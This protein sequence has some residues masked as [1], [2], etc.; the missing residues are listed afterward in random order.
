[1]KIL[2]VLK[3]KNQLKK[4]SEKEIGYVKKILQH[5][6]VEPNV[7]YLTEFES[8]EKHWLSATDFDSNISIEKYWNRIRKN[9][10]KKSNAKAKQT[11]K[12]IT[13]EK[14]T[15]IPEKSIIQTKSGRIVKQKTF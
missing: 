15:N 9:K 12:Q 8:G 10:S 13:N 6:G 2:K 1:L 14:A 3:L 11:K 4:S 7:K 5:E